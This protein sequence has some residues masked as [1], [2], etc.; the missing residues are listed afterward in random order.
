V[1]DNFVAD[2]MGLSLFI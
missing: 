2:I 1:G